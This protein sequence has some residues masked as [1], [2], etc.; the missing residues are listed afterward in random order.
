MSCRRIAATGIAAATV[1]VLGLSRW[2]LLVPG[3]SNDATDPA[4]TTDTHRTFE[5]LHT[6]LGTILGE[7]IG[8]ALTAT[9]AL[10]VAFALIRGLAP[11]G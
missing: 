10:L 2:V 11:D 7:P 3:L 5:L 9:F 4:R 8:F 6:W 1:Q